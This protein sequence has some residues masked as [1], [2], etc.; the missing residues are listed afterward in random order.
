MDACKLNL[1]MQEGIFDCVIDKACFDAILC[2]DNSK[3]NSEN[4]LN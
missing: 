1:E 2:G 4:M 3:T